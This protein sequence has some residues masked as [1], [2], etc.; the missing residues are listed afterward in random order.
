M[1]RYLGSQNEA[2]VNAYCDIAQEVSGIKQIYIIRL[3][4]YMQEVRQEVNIMF[5]VYDW[6]TYNR[7][8]FLL[9]N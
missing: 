8:A 3:W 5:V 6:T 1:D 2:A 7:R 9:R 4:L